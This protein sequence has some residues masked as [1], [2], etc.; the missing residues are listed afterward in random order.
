LPLSTR[1][2]NATRIPIIGLIVM[3][4]VVERPIF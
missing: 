2:V 4:E 3:V 1:L